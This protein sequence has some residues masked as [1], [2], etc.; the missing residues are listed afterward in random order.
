MAETAPLAGLP[1]K[2]YDWAKIKRVG[3]IA[4]NTSAAFL[5][6]ACRID[7][8]DSFADEYSPAPIEPDAR[9]SLDCPSD[10]QLI[11]PVPEHS[12]N[13]EPFHTVAIDIELNDQPTSE[14]RFNLPLLDKSSSLTERDGENPP[15]YRNPINNAT[16]LMLDGQIKYTILTN[17]GNIIQ[18]IIVTCSQD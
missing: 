5:L 2:K 3:Q 10:Q 12:D 15:E 4:A 9:Y 1:D 7:D 14:I 11:I 6:A 18:S 13:S 16:H 17:D 8:L